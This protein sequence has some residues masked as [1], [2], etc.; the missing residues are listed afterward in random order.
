MA[1]LAAAQPTP[2]IIWDQV[3]HDDEVYSVAF[4]ADGASPSASSS[5]SSGRTA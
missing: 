2:D 3:G 4:T 1:P 5:A